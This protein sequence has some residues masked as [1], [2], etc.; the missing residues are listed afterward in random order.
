MCIN[1]QHLCVWERT[2][3]ETKL[4]RRAVSNALHLS[5]FANGEG[6]KGQVVG[7]AYSTS[8]GIYNAV[9]GLDQ[10]HTGVIY[11]SEKSNI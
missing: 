9:C 6:A 4:R 5:S 8:D 3:V 1:Q 11:I 2:I 10:V 7:N